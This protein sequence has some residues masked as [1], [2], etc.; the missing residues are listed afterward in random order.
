MP[1]FEK[2]K[3]ASLV[4]F[5]E[6]HGTSL[7]DRLSIQKE[8]I[9]LE[10]FLGIEKTELGEGIRRIRFS[11][12]PMLIS[13]YEFPAEVLADQG[14]QFINIMRGSYKQMWGDNLE[15]VIVKREPTDGGEGSIYKTKHYIGIVEVDGEETE[16]ITKKKVYINPA[17]AGGLCSDYIPDDLAFWNIRNVVNGEQHS[18]WDELGNYFV[19]TNGHGI[20]TE[21]DARLRVPANQRTAKYPHGFEKK[22]EFQSDKTPIGWAAM[23]LLFADDPKDKFIA[24]QLCDEFR[25]KVLTINNKDGDPIMLDFTRTEYVLGLLENQIVELNEQA[26]LLKRD[27]PGYWIDNVGAGDYLATLISQGQL[28]LQDLL[29]IYEQAYQNFG[30]QNYAKLQQILTEYELAGYDAGLIYT[31]V[32][33]SQPSENTYAERM[34]RFLTD[35]RMFKYLVPWLNAEGNTMITPN[36][37][38][39]EFQDGMLHKVGDG[40]YSSLLI[41]DPWRLSNLRLLQAAKLKYEPAGNEDA[42]KTR[43]YL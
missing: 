35:P 1:P 20:G 3:K 13:A 43:K 14:Q 2:N 26:H 21:F 22:T 7:Q 30:F 28:G 39:Q 41:P 33:S 4:P 17:F 5:I 38:A 15:D 16:Y 9:S 10:N 32:D 11:I 23:E 29:P 6:T 25:T 31:R 12:G 19:R 34:G 24:C 8:I 42:L 18:L 36:L 27:A 40:P 37:S